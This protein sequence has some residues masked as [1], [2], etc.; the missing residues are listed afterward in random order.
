MDSIEHAK[1]V[2]KRIKDCELRSGVYRK[3]IFH[4]H[5]PASYDYRLCSEWKAE[6]Y[7]NCSVE[8]VIELC[9]SRHVVP[10]SFNLYDFSFEGEL[11]EQF[12]DKKEWLS[13][14]LIAGTLFQNKYEVVLVS[15][16]N[17]LS[18]I[19][20]VKNAVVGYYNAFHKGR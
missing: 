10:E 13:Y 12:L 19:E 5:T 16:H 9:Y 20:K 7:G 14:L 15:D 3:T 17:T 1:K 4:L 6:D 11:E 2:Y 18:G 8:D